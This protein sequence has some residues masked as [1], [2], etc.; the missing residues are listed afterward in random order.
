MPQAW[1]LPLG[2]LCELAACDMMR[3]AICNGQGT[4][5]ELSCVVEVGSCKTV[6]TLYQWDVAA[7]ANITGV[8][9]GFRHTNKCH[10]YS[11]L[12]G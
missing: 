2:T 12:L 7:V 1:P 11:A 4:V 9:H 5:A 10:C 3:Y 8:A 6:V